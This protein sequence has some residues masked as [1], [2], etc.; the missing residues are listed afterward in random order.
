[1]TTELLWI[2]LTLTAFGLLNRILAFALCLIVF[3]KTGRTKGFQDVAAVFG[4]RLRRS[5]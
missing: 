4:P 2:T 5:A 3:I 1:M